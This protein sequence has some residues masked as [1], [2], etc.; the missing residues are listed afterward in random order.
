MFILLFSL[1]LRLYSGIVA[2]THNLI[3]GVRAIEKKNFDFKISLS[4]GDEWDS[5]AETFN[6]AS[7]SLEELEAARV[8]QEKLLPRQ[9]NPKQ[10]IF[11]HRKKHHVD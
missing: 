3:D 2:P 8:V 9:K 7:V 1:G 11:I 5:L 6:S 4:T 10:G